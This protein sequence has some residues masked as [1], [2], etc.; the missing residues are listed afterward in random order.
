MVIMQNFE[1]ICDTFNVIG[2][3][4]DENYIQKMVINCTII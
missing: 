1:V 2:I 3:C 4:S